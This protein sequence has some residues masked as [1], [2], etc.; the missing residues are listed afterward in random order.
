MQTWTVVFLLIAS[1]AALSGVVH[2]YTIMTRTIS[3]THYSTTGRLTSCNETVIFSCPGET[4]VFNGRCTVKTV[5]LEKS[6]TGWFVAPGW[7]VLHAAPEGIT[8]SCPP[9]S[10]QGRTGYFV[11]YFDVM[12]AGYRRRVGDGALEWSHGRA[13]KVVQDIL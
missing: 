3:A 13:G 6:P 11:G 4:H 7:L 8:A 9:D 2:G 5:W 1:A 10:L 12:R